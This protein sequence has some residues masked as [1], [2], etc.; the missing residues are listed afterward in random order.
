MCNNPMEALT[1]LSA[2]AQPNL[3][4]HILSKE[5]IKELL[6][7]PPSCLVLGYF[8]ILIT[9]LERAT[10]S[11]VGVF[12]KDM[13]GDIEENRTELRVIQVLVYHLEGDHE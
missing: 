4:N 5:V 3:L 10:I 7:E 2:F 6:D 11:A 8:L 12:S 9:R 13:V 1:Q